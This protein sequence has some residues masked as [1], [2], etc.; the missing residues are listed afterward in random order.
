MG[1]PTDDKQDARLAADRAAIKRGVATEVIAYKRKFATWLVETV[2]PT[3][4]A[5]AM[6]AV[7]ETAF[8]WCIDAFGED[9]AMKFIGSAFGAVKK[10]PPLH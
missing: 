9:D 7:M 4:Q 3:S 1:D 8:D 10:R 2:H 5:S 6:L